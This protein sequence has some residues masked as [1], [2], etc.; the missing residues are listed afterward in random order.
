MNEPRWLDARE[1]RAWRRYEQMRT[2]LAVAL[3]RQLTRDSGLSLADY[4]VLVHL[5]ESP[6][7]RLRMFE[8]GRALQW[9]KSRVSHHV[10]RMQGRG[11]VDREECETDGR[12]AFIVITPVGRAAIEEAAPGHLAAVRRYLVDALSP[13]QLEALGDIAA[14]VLERLAED[15]AATVPLA[16]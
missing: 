14:I 11:L 16:S 8:L 12:G 6:S 9:E 1:D 5:S 15:D 10:R 13:A 2:Q 7:G 4:E 3:N